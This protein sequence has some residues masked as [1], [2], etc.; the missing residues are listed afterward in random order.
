MNQELLS[1]SK[2]Q[3]VL[4]RKKL[5][6]LL[7]VGVVACVGVLLV[8]T[9]RTEAAPSNLIIEGYESWIVEEFQKWTAK[10][11]KVYL[12][13]EEATY[14]LKVF[15]D[16]FFKIRAE[17]E[18]ERSYRLGLTKFADLTQEEFGSRFAKRQKTRQAD[19]ET[20]TFNTSNVPTSIDWRT[21]NAVTPVGDD[22]LCGACWAFTSVGAIE[23]LVAIKTGK[24]N[25]FSKQAIVDCSQSYG[26]EGCISGVAHYTINYVIDHGI[27]LE[28][29]YPY[30]GKVQT[31]QVD[32]IKADFTTRTFNYLPS[33][34][35]DQLVAGIANQPVIVTLSAYN[36]VFQFYIGGII[37]SRDCGTELSQDGLAVG[38]D[39][40]GRQ[41]YYIVKNSWGTDWGEQ[42]YV[43]IA[44]K[45]GKGKGM[46]GIAQFSSVPGV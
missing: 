2:E 19:V 21:K 9:T 8:F 32:S 4:S 18:Q 22:G 31:C 12:T 42:G 45:G 36:L 11:N 33:N 37:D 1:G 43:R 34:D 41:K 44:R 5:L 20:T 25:I 27:P 40:E 17:M 28:S 3:L 46:C 16:N 13:F 10:Y 26:N 23:G 15:R 35:E 38:Y 30:V 14:R 7:F 39:A 29:D 24:L 6:A